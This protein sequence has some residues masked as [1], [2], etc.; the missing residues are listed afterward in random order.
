[1]TKHEYTPQ[2]K[3]TLKAMFLNS[4]LVFA[5]FNMVKMEGNAFTATI[6]PA[7]DELYNDP[8]ERKKAL[9]RHNGFFNTNAVPFCFIAGLTYALEKEKIMRG[10]VTDDTIE[11]I[12]VALMG[13]TAGIGDAFFFNC[14]RVIV[15]GIS[16]GLC[17]QG[18]ILGSILFVLLYGGSQLLARWYLLKMGY[19]M[20][21]SFIENIFRTGLMDSITKAASIIGLTM[22]GAMVASM[23]DV[24]MIWTIQVGSASVAILN[25][26]NSVMPGIL[27]IILTFTMVALIRKGYRPVVLVMGLLCISIGLAYFGIF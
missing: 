12:K 16:I 18:N 21:L 9:R 2:E 25:V 23:V 20:G 3:K 26:L 22:V 13:P 27:S 14:I 6:A 10:S 15:A 7:I 1:M 24:K 17:A 19:S 11:N 8:E 4:G 5:S